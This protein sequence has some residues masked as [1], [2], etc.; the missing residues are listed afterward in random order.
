[1]KRYA[2]R[3]AAMFIALA[4]LAVFPAG[5]DLQLREMTNLP[6]PTPRRLPKKRKLP[7]SPTTQ[8]RIFRR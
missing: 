3:A 6:P 2:Q 4:L 7:K 5:C 8:V 1:M